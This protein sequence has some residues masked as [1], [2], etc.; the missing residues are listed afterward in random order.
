MG[1]YERKK[2]ETLKRLFEITLIP[3]IGLMIAIFLSPF[4]L[5]Q[6]LTFAESSVFCFET[7][8]CF[9]I[10]LVEKGILTVCIGY[11]I[12]YIIRYL[13]KKIKES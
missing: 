8:L 11:Q 2:E 12:F 4:F 7:C 3:W 6:L 1:Y 10:F 5:V 9:I 13:I